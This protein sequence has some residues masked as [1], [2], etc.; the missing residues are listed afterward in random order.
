MLK[1]TCPTCLKHTDKSTGA[2]NRARKLGRSIYCGRKCAGVGRGDIRTDEQKKEEK[3]IY[4]KEYRANNLE[5]IKRKKSDYFQKTYDPEKAAI[6][7]KKNM[8]RH[9]EYCRQPEY[10]AWKKEYDKKYKAKKNYGEFW[11]CFLL[12]NEITDECL[13]RESAYDIKYNNGLLCKTQRR[14]RHEQTKRNQLEK[15]TMGNP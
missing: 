5:M 10:K 3:R 8:S 9:V 6:E 14:K 2:V 13:S 7:R 12:T 11:E 1:I 4:D 15:C